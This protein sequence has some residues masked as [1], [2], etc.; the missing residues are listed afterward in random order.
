VLGLMDKTDVTNFAWIL[1]AIFFWDKGSVTRAEILHSADAINH[2]VPSDSEL[3]RAILYLKEQG[4]IEEHG[5]SFAISDAGREI[6]ESAHGGSGNI[7][8]VWKALELRIAS[9]GAA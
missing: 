6:L 7:F 1:L 5:H 4:L 2:A 3:E 8:D 9:L